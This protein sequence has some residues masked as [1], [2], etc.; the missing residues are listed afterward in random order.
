MTAYIK[1]TDFTHTDG[2]PHDHVSSTIWRAIAERLVFVLPP[3]PDATPMTVRV[4]PEDGDMIPALSNT[5]LL[6]SNRHS[7]EVVV[8]GVSPGSRCLHYHLF[9]ISFM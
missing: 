3:N 7:I 8:D 9:Y 6:L 5:T 2:T 4:Q 1:E